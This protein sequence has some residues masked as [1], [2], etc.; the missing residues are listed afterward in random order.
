MSTANFSRMLRW[1]VV[2]RAGHEAL[3][4]GATRLTYEQLDRQVDRTAHA[5]HALGCEPGS[6]VALL[7]RNS[8]QFVIDLF[9]IARLGAIVLPLNCRLKSAELEYI[10]GHSEAT[11]VLA[12]GEFAG[13]LAGL[14]ALERVERVALHDRA[15][16]LESAAYL[17]DLI[18]AAGDEPI[19]DA[20][21]HS[22]GVSRIMYTS[23]TTARPK[24]VMTTWGNL[25]ANQLGQILELELTPADRVL[26][27][28]PLFHVAAL[29]APGHHILSV[30]GTLVIARNFRAKELLELAAAERVTGMV[31]AG[32]IVSDMV[33][34]DEVSQY[35]L[36]ALRYAIFGSLPP[37]RRLQLINLL[38][39]ARVIDTF[40][41]TELTNGVAYMD[42][43]HMLDKL[44]AC[45]TPFPYMDIAIFDP[46]GQPVSA[47]EAGEIAVR[48]P[49]VSPGY[50]KDPDATA[51]AWR[52]GWFRTGDLGRID[53][54]GFLWFVDRLKDVIRSG[55]ENIAG[56]EIERVLSTHPLVGEVA[57]VGVPDP[58]WGEVPKAFLVPRGKASASDSELAEFCAAQLARFKVP[59]SFEWLE[60]LPR[61]ASGKVLKRDL[62][63]LSAAAASRAATAAA[64]IQEKG[65]EA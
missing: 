63:A 4:D 56:A 2:R 53:E 24:G 1:N 47:G 18:E 35:D 19:P 33:A 50:W 54:D 27:S 22:N 41:M 51:A 7:A 29:E 49:K 64:A 38:P 59:R 58:R 11:L 6:V 16:E 60:E 34:L 5:I 62:R 13:V 25:S 61:N 37:D 26:A 9:A 15:G 3:V 30:G 8:A 21:V 40:G 12:D 48:G 14:A 65:P 44:G 31:L 43:A 20:E 55:G 39:R 23:G 42:G 52:G 10:V 45:G 46:D 28:G 32:A 36:S 57:V 17:P